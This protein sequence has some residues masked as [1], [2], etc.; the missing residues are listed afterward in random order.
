MAVYK[1]DILDVELN[2]G[3]I[4]RS[5]L[6]H[7]I[8]KDDT[9]ADRF[10]V[11][12]YRDGEPESLSGCSI[13]GYMMRPNGTNLAI[14]GSNTGVSGNEAW[15]DL[16][17][18]AYDYEGQFCLALKLIGGGVT[19]TIRIIDGMINNT[20]V[21]DAVAPT[22][23]VPTYQEILAVYDQMV[24][25]KNGSVRFDTEQTLT[26][27]QKTQAR[28]NIEAA[29]ESDVSDLKSALEGM[30]PGTEK[31]Y[32]SGGYINCA[33]ETIDRTVIVPSV[34][35]KYIVDSCVP[36]DMYLINASGAASAKPW[37]FIDSIGKRLTYYTSSG[38]WACNMQIVQAPA[39]AA[40]LISNYLIADTPFPFVYK[41]TDDVFGKSKTL[42]YTKAVSVPANSNFNNYGSTGNYIV[43]DSATAE[44]IDNI[45]EEISGRLTVYTLTNQNAIF[46]VFEGTSGNIS[47]RA[48]T[49]GAWI[50]W[51][52]VATT[53]FVSTQIA[54]LGAP[55]PTKTNYI[56]QIQSNSDLDD[57]KTAGSYIV[58]TAAIART[59]DNIPEQ[60]S[61]RLVVLATSASA[62]VSQIF[63]TNTNRMYSRIYN[64]SWTVWTPINSGTEMELGQLYCTQV[65]SESDFDDFTTPGNYKVMTVAIANTILHIPENAG[66]RLTVFTLTYDSAV[67]QWYISTN[68]NWYTRELIGGNWSTWKRIADYDYVQAETKKNIAAKGAYNALQAIIKN[69]EYDIAF[70]NAFSPISLKNY[71]GNTQNVHPKVL[72]FE[73]GFGG[74]KYWMAY[75]PYPYSQDGYENPCIAYSDNGYAWTNIEGN[76]LDDPN[77]VGYNSDT[78]LVYN[79]ANSTLE[80]WYRYVRD[81]NDPPIEET[82]YRQTTTDGVTWSTKELV[83]SNTS[84]SYDRLLSPAIIIDNNKYCIWVVSGENGVHIDYYEAPV[85]DVTDWTNIRSFN[86]TYTDDG[87]AVNPWHLDVIKDGS[88]YAMLVMCRNSTQIATA[89]CS[90]FMAISSDNITYQT[91]VKVVGG[92]DN[93]DKYMYRSSIVKVGSVYRIYYSA[94]GGGTTTI[95]ANSVWGIGITESNS[96]TS[97]YIG[98]Y[99]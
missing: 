32:T 1:A 91:P 76:P 63:I 37:T 49:S 69:S 77:G 38:D 31:A 56:S 11:R 51:R 86:L 89:K 74:H 71:L 62:I 52:R 65:T 41:F 50:E 7:N 97:G 21:S 53:S 13:Q 24:A 28:G 70:A 40:Y 79:T 68:N 66:G 36:G 99:Q 95:Y 83:Y 17:Q 93:W 44:S 72:Y 58:Y 60:Y 39:N 46:Q 33:Q 29:S 96:L 27:A 94:T 64:S 34:N 10:G 61:G 48:Y 84:G 16:P 19:G 14:T 45:P 22:A 8:G 85:S 4:A 88:S 59:I 78:H 47:W 35:Y 3:N 75:T 15:V 90:L 98:R 42:N 12:V 82:I 80:C 25:A 26:A 73:N 20:F 67:H 6:C 30:N 23:A 57:Y 54:N 43:A 92:A 81:A 2:T 87:T 9:K 5:F 18:A 55:I